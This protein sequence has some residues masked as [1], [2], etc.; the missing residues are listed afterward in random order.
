MTTHK[1]FRKK[2]LPTYVTAFALAAISSAQAAEN[3]AEEIIV[4]GIRA[5]Q[6]AAVDVKRKA[7]N[8]V[9]S[10]VAEDIGKL[11]DVSITD[12]L[13]RIT[14]VQ[15]DRTAGEGTSLNVRGMPQVLTTLNGEQFLSPWS[16]TG[17]GANFGDISPSMISGADVHKS[18][19][20]STLAGGISGVVDL[21][22]RKPLQLP[23]GFTASGSLD[24]SQ[25]SITDK[26][27]YDHNAF[28][29]W[30][31][32]NI[33]VTVGA[34]KSDTN[35][36]NYSMSED[37]RL[38]FVN[39][40]GDPL[41]LN[42]NGD[43]TD[44]YLVPGGYGVKA[45]VMEREREGASV[46]FQADFADAWT[47][48][49]DVFYTKMDQYDRGVETQF[50]GSND[51]G[52]DVLRPG[53]ITKKEAT[54][55][56]SGS[57]PTRVI[58]SVQVAVVEAPDFQ[59]TTKSRQNHTDA[60][61]SN[62]ELAYDSGDAF[63]GSVRYVHATAEKEYEEATF[64][65]GTPAW[66]WID[67]DPKDDK[68]DARD[69]FL[70]TVDYTQEY[71]TFS[72]NDDLSGIDRLNLFQAF[73]YG[74][75][76]EASLDVFRADGSYEFSFADFTSIDFGLRYGTRDV[77]TTKY[78]YL[79]PTG[80]YST[81][82]DPA[83]PSD[84]W[85]KKLPGD[86]VW[87]KYP[88]WYDFK[89]D[90]GLQLPAF[91]ALKSQLISYN[92]FGPFKGFEKG[93]SALDPKSLDD[94]T[95]FMNFLYPGAQKMADPAK[96]YTVVEDS[97]SAYLQAN[98]END[99]GVFGIPYSGN[100]GVQVVQTDRE[101]TKGVY[102][103]V[104]P[105]PEGTF[106]GG[107]YNA[108]L[109]KPDL[110]Q[111]TFKT[112]GT[113]TVSA[114]Y[115]D[116][117][118]AV[119][120]NFFPREDVI[121]RAS[122]NQTMTRNDLVNVGEGVT[123]WYQDFRVYTPD[124]DREDENGKYKQVNGPGGGSDQGNP[125]I[126]PW[127]ADNYNMSAEWYF[128][129]GSILGVSIFKIDVKSATQGLQ[130]QRAYADSDGVTRRS[131]NI[132]T[133]KNVGAAPLQGLEIGYKQSFDFLPGLLSKTGAEFNYTYS[134]STSKDKDL[135]GVAFPLQS[136]SEH[137]YNAVLWYQDDKLGARLAYNW[138][139]DIFQGRNGLN[140][141]EAPI[142]LGNWTEAAGFLDASINYNILENVTV[143]LQGTNL[144]ETSDRRYAQ[145]ESQFNSINVQERRV[146]LGLRVK[147]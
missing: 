117:L 145:F 14:G 79:T 61:N 36:A 140:T 105:P 4:T 28:V 32:D 57:T 96:G 124:G 81:W 120:I 52:Y 93:V 92:D 49:G 37:S 11:P 139:S 134:D 12:S 109:G 85:R 17:V 106:L 118:P 30:H 70:V 146:S 133:T 72:Y 7:V 50:N 147:L 80:Y 45:Y 5:S 60:L 26:L 115:T 98:F 1:S 9:D 29:G 108:T 99:T 73:G 89:G 103:L 137:Q 71:P 123:L 10:I 31:Q 23:D 6:Q 63:K 82:D 39:R 91:D 22:T 46:S 51:N 97:T 138:R 116:V 67:V 76:D 83:V 48:T 128:S 90:A 18:Q 144:T 78:D 119:N 66:Y 111:G 112:L 69:P 129:E 35:A 74:Q 68:N 102:P 64:Q 104:S 87:Q 3:E 62:F 58:N 16:I 33:G 122:Y 132:W 38:G 44:R 13:Q 40:G 27:N 75:K 19:S 101:V 127:R 114:S 113:K 8:I 54:I 86:A 130:E 20:A 55:P 136:N 43:V 110:W 41:D 47:F 126:K 65:Q 42:N 125:D 15:I 131:V 88:N 77:T 21:K 25:G 94:V 141:N 59:A 56:A 135:E 107:G 84:L 143:S 100:L 142:N 121:V 24:R 95:G 34:F 2:L 53:T